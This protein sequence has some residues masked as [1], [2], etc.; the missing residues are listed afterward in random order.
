[1]N[2]DGLPGLGM[3]KHRLWPR[4]RSLWGFGSQEAVVAIHDGIDWGTAISVLTKV[5]CE[6]G[7][8]ERHTG[9]VAKAVREAE[10]LF[11]AW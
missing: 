10:K 7:V 11:G 8:F 4:W 5:E 6:H 1:M 3:T 9:T 2:T